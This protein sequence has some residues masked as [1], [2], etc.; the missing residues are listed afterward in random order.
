MIYICV[1]HIRRDIH[2]ISVQ[3][4][5]YIRSCLISFNSHEK[6]YT[7]NNLTT[8][9]CRRSHIQLF[10]KKKTNLQSNNVHCITNNRSGQSV[11]RV[12]RFSNT[13]SGQK[14][15]D[16]LQYCVGP[17]SALITAGIILGIDST[18]F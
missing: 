18:S 16:T 7:V 13:L 12:N 3:R 2:L 14:I 5:S 11:N 4:L 15:R 8:G 10:W 6:Y 1:T 9:Q 17:L